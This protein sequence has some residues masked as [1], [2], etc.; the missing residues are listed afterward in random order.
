MQWSVAG[1]LELAVRAGDGS[2]NPSAAAKPGY[3]H[4]GKIGHKPGIDRKAKAVVGGRRPLWGIQLIDVGENA[5]V[6]AAAVS[7]LPCV[8]QSCTKDELGNKPAS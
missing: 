4:F 2:S 8:R 7:D 1:K 3:L 5:A 6:L